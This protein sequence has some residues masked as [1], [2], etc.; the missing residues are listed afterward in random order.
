VSDFFQSEIVQNSIREMYDLQNEIIEKTF[1]SPFGSVDE[2]VKQVNLMRVFLEKQKNLYVRL[3]LSDDPEAKEMV[4]RVGE[5]ATLLG[6]D[7]QSSMIEFFAAMEKSVDGLE[8][9]ANM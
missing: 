8:K 7:G 3:T 1:K 2:K 4:E 9:L 6:Y 5:A